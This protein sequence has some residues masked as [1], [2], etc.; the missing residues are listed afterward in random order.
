M[1]D[2]TDYI[3]EADSDLCCGLASGVEAQPPLVQ[4][5]P[6]HR[7]PRTGICEKEIGDVARQRS[8]ARAGLLTELGGSA[9]PSRARV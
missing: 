4:R 9:R 8:A 6:H 1:S 2:H 5:R 3:A 7:S